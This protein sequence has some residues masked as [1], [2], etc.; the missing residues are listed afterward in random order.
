MSTFQ[1]KP[2]PRVAVYPTSWA[3]PMTFEQLHDDLAHYASNVLKS[4]C[5][6][7]H[8]LPDCLQN[9]FMALWETL[10]AQ[11]D[12][13][14]EKTRRQAVFFILARSKISTMQYRAQMYE[15]LDA[16]ISDDWHNTVD[17][18]IDGM[19]HQRGERW[20]GWATE[21]DMR[22]DIERVMHKLATKYADSLRHLA[23]LYYLTTQV[24][25]QDAAGIA[26]MT[27]WNWVQS[28]VLPVMAEVR[29]EFAEAFLETHE[30]P[31]PKP[32]IDHPDKNRSNGRFVSPYLAWREQY[33]AGHTAPAETLLDQYRHTPCLSLALQAQ[34]DGKGYRTAAADVG[35]SA[36]TFKK[37]M[38]RAARLLSE[39]YAG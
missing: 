27:P 6:L 32:I 26:G 16:M 28:Y 30:Y 13:L 20:A 37:H 5:V 34:I 11:R 1:I 24:S 8:Q 19:Q 21:I 18:Q 23:A 36:N 9:G 22:I 38:N 25:R 29:Y 4:Y 31:A 2:F 33:S 3:E 35:R 14:K 7:P 12:F 10:S 39:A 15:S 17:E